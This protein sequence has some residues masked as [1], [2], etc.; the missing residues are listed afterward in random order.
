MVITSYIM[1]ANASKNVN[2]QIVL[3]VYRFLEVTMSRSH[4]AHVLHE[5]LILYYCRYLWIPIQLLPEWMGDW[6]MCKMQRA[7]PAA[8]K[9]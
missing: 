6:F 8:C 2:V 4:A 7:V 5:N 9:Q 1:M 3:M